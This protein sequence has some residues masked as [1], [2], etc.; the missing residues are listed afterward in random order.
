MTPWPGRRAE[1]SDV[2]SE[3][4]V[5][6]APRLRVCVLVNVTDGWRNLRGLDGPPAVCTD[7]VPRR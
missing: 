4:D 2:A 1:H 5:R 6:V 7:V 3:R